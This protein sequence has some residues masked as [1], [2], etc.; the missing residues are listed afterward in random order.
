MSCNY[1]K[2]VIRIYPNA[3]IEIRFIGLE[4]QYR[5]K[6]WTIDNQYLSRW[7]QRG[8]DAWKEAALQIKN[9]NAYKAFY[10]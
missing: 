3:I 5:V 4:K 8:R 7:Y 10:K 9:E 2:Q 1:K 6:D